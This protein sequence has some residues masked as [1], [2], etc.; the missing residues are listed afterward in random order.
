MSSIPPSLPID[1]ED[2]PRTGTPYGNPYDGKTLM[3]P[4]LYWI[5]TKKEKDAFFR[6]PQFS[7]DGG[8]KECYEGDCVPSEIQHWFTELRDMRAAYDLHFRMV[9]AH[10]PEDRLHAVVI[11]PVRATMRDHDNENI[12]QLANYLGIQDHIHFREW[13]GP[14]PDLYL[15]GDM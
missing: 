13:L 15:A 7:F 1:G 8:I 4:G 10:F 3:H 2:C 9:V 14:F 5:F 11:G 6:R 12:G